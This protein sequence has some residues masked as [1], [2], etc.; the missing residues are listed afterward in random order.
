MR[1]GEEEQKICENSG[2]DSSHRKHHE[3]G[4]KERAVGRIRHQLSAKGSLSF[5]K[6]DLICV[7]ISSFLTTSFKFEFIVLG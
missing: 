3:H 5:F 2:I 1:G 6:F 7:V 4:N